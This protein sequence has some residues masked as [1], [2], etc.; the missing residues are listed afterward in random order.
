MGQHK[1]F[2]VRVIRGRGGLEL[3]SESKT[4]RGTTFAVAST[5]IATLSDDRESRAGQIKTGI[6]ELIARSETA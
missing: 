6:A 2:R 5:K 1:V 3:R 4:D